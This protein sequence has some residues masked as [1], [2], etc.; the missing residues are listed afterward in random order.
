MP[1]ITRT[2]LAGD[3]RAFNALLIVPDS[4]R[5]RARAALA[6]RTAT[7]TSSAWSPRPTC[8]LAPYERV[9]NFAL[10]DRDFS[11]EQRRTDAEGIVP[12]QADRDELR[13][14]HRRACTAATGA[15]C[16]GSDRAV[17]V[18][19]WVLR[20]L[21]VLEDAIQATSHG[22]VDT[23]RGLHAAAR[24]G[25]RAGLAGRSATSSTASRGPT[26]RST[27]ASSRASRCSGW[28][29]RRSTAFLPCKDGWDHVLDGVDDQV[30]LPERDGRG[31]RRRA[32]PRRARPA[33]AATR[34]PLPPRALRPVRTMPS[35]PSPRSRRASTQAPPHEA[36]LLRRRLE[37]LANHPVEAVR[38]RAYLILILD[39][40][41]PS[42]TATCRPSCTRARPSSRARAS[43][44]SRARASSPGACRASAS[45]CTSTAPGSTG[46]RRRRCASSSWTC[47]TCWRTSARFH[48]DYYPT[49]R[50]ELA[51]WIVFDRDPELAATPLQLLLE[52][53]AWYE[54]Y[55]SPASRRRPT[56]RASCRSRKV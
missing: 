18:P 31:D 8:D 55:Q 33:A 4:D 53:G 3:G 43:S 27:S 41:S 45:G 16:A 20:D 21:G 10:L 19:H 35:P 36:R 29:I 37:A 1:G 13:R 46:R 5:P 24:A 49:V 7:T 17:V 30:T 47:C 6:T 11:A 50:R 52:L 54:E 32:L 56:G 26:R 48:V 42:T 25:T 38:C 28:A 34:R 51:C 15:R 2:F 12:A 39:R 40:P 23:R 9:V 14:G 22:L 44:T